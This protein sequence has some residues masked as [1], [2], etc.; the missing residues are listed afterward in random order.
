[1]IPEKDMTIFVR[2]YAPLALEAL[3][4][5]VVEGDAPLPEIE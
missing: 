3:V 2:K 1:M 5:T 4:S